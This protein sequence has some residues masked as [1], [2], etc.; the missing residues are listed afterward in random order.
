MKINFDIEELDG[1]WIA[2]AMPAPKSG[3]DALLGA[4]ANKVRRAFPTQEMLM[5]A[6]PEMIGEAIT[7]ERQV[8]AGP[9]HRL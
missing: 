7:K 2:T 5:A 1:I 8:E 3:F 9:G 4:G 6:L